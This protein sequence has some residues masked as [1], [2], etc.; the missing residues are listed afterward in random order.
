MPRLVYALLI[1]L[2]ILFG[3]VF[4]LSRLDGAHAVKT[5]EIPVTAPAATK[6]S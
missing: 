5:I 1:A 2:I 3:L 6:A 4:L